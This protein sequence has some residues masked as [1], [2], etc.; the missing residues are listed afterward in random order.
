MV[1]AEIE[2]ARQARGRG[3]VWRRGGAHRAGGVREEQ[4]FGGKKVSAS[5]RA[6]LEGRGLWVLLEEVGG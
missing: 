1:F 6:C 4:R 2:P 3:D 5:K